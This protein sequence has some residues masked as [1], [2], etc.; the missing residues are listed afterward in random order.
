MSARDPLSTVLHY[1]VY[2]RVILA[3]L[4]GLRMCLH[5]PR[6]SKEKTNL[7][8][9]KSF[10]E[11]CKVV[12]CQNRFGKNA[13][14]MGGTFAMA[15][16][17]AAATENQGNDTPPIHGIMALATPYQYKT[18]L[19]IRDLIQKDVSNFERIK[20][21]IAHMCKEDHFDNEGHQDSLE[22]LEKARAAGLAGMP[23]FRIAS[24]PSFLQGRS[25]SEKQPS[26]WDLP[27][28]NEEKA[29]LWQAAVNDDAHEYKK[30]F[31]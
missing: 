2:V 15:E 4:A 28:E 10:Y 20:R 9:G 24:K 25:P 26:L 22:S 13:R 30:E 3:Y 1:D 12:P 19:E 14:V 16:S 6:C 17:L 18:L 7:K 27:T 11:K 29:A 8:F 23:H 21:F 5:C 31:E